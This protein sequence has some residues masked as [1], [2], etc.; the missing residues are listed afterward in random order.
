M[1]F[2]CE[3]NIPTYV[4]YATRCSTVLHK[5]ITVQQ[6]IY[7]QK[8]KLMNRQ[9]ILIFL[10]QSKSYICN[11]Y[12]HVTQIF[13]LIQYRIYLF[14][15]VYTTNMNIYQILNK[16]MRK[17]KLFFWQDEK[18]LEQNITNQQKYA[19]QIPSPITIIKSCVVSNHSLK[20]Y[21]EDGCT[22]HRV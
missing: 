16:T 9:D 18:I 3:S 22:L 11:I 8:T 10:H 13:N 5:I 17:Q 4:V 12:V 1:H 15:V 19:G 21:K 6:T 7:R 14:Q 20:L 2:Q